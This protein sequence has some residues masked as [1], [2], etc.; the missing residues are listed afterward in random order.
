MSLNIIGGII[1]VL[2][3]MLIAS[4]IRITAYIESAVYR[5]QNIEDKLD[6]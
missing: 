4:T 6:A 2:L 3:L 5:L 1:I